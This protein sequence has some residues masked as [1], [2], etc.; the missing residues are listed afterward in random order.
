[1]MLYITPLATHS[2]NIC[3]FVLGMKKLSEIRVTKFSNLTAKYGTGILMFEEL[4][5]IKTGTYKKLVLECRAALNEGD[6]DLYVKLKSKLPAVTFCGEFE[7]GRKASA[8]TTY[9]N[10]MVIDIDTIPNDDL[11]EVKKKLFKDKYI[12]S[13]WNSPS[14]RG[15]KCLI[16]IDSNIEKHRAVFNS[17]QK[18]FIDNFG[19]ELDVSGKDV[20]RLCFSSWDENIFYNQNSEIYL[21]FLE[22]DKKNINQHKERKVKNVSLVKNAHATE[23]LNRPEDRNTMKKIIKYLIKR[24]LSI[25]ETYDNWLKVSF[26]ISSSFSYD[27]GEKYFLNLC[28]LDK[29]KHDEIKSISLLK[30]SYNNRQ[31]E[32]KTSIS[33]ATMIFLA[34]EKGFKV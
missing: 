33:F 25:T 13:L 1:M 10:L 32:S 30:Y 11:V 14:G 34:K 29:S 27:V 8:I 24:N 26:A 6:K 12:L 4:K 23:G 5:H 19:I 17:I 22:L 15:I 7:K 3:I 16:K 28:R 21:D 31:I 20:S 18:Y 9:N 2:T